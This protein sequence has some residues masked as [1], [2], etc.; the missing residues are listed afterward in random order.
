MSVYLVGRK[1]IR[2][3][4]MGGGRQSPR[5]GWYGSSTTKGSKEERWGRKDGRGKREPRLK[6]IRK[7]RRESFRILKNKCIEVEFISHKVNHFKSNHS[8]GF[9][10]IHSVHHCLCLVSEYFPHSIPLKQFLCARPS[11]PPG[12]HSSVLSPWVY[13]FGIFCINGIIQHVSCVSGFFHLA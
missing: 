12:N 4:S 5:P 3:V 11:L 6:C 1:Q 10:Y 2:G 7:F 13:P 9:N 8:V